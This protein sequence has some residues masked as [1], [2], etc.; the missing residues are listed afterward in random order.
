MNIFA[1]NLSDDEI[2]RLVASNEREILAAQAKINQLVKS[3]N[4]LRRAYN[5]RQGLKGIPVGQMMVIV[6]GAKG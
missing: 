4:Q 3:N 2:M 6:G 5:A 1:Q